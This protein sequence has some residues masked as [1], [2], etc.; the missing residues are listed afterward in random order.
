MK[1]N[2]ILLLL[3][4]LS[5]GFAFSQNSL[6]LP[7]RINSFSMKTDS[8]NLIITPWS[9]NIIRISLAEK[10]ESNTT[11]AVIMKPSEVN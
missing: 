11:D 10:G 1:L 2:I 4:F 6:S 5:G 7:V 8:G 3:V 9:Q